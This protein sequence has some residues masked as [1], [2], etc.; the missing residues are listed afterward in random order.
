MESRPRSGTRSGARHQLTEMN[1]VRLV[2]LLL[3]PLAVW[4]ACGPGALAAETVPTPTGPTQTE[5][6]NAQE[7][8]RSYLQLQEQ[9]HATELAIERGRKEADRAADRTSQ[10]LDERLKTIEPSLEVQRAKELE[11]MQSNNRIMLIVAG[12]F[13]G[14]GFLAMVLM[15]YFQWR[16]VKHLAEVSAALPTGAGFG[17]GSPL[18]T[19]GPGDSHLVS[20]GPAEQSSLRLLGAIEQLDKRMQQIELSGR[21]HLMEGDAPTNGASLAYASSNGESSSNGEALPKEARIH[22]LLGKGQSLLNLD[23]AEGALVCFEEILALDPKQTDALLKKGTALERLR[24]LEEA[25]GCYDRAL[26]ADASLTIAHLYK[27]GLLNRMERF[28]EALDCYEQA[29]RTQEQQN[30]AA[31]S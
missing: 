29:L 14:I 19:L 6:T 3:F 21:P 30:G 22:M 26:A 13:A 23:D 10:A 27:G 1:R 25:I 9:I 12:T 20:V 7:V 5:E 11:A 16:T 2:L 17:L 28:D 8:L 31:V 18:A 4:P 15:A 24:K